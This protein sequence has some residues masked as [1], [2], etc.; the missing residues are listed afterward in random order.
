MDPDPIVLRQVLA[1]AIRGRFE[2]SRLSMC[3]RRALLAAADLEG[4]ARL[5]G[6]KYP[7]LRRDDRTAL[8]G[9]V[10]A[11]DATRRAVRVL[12]NAGVRCLVLKGIAVASLAWE[13]PG[14]RGQADVDLLIAPA[15]I[16]RAAQVLR[17]AGLVIR[18]KL[19]GPDWHHLVLTMSEP[20]A[21]SLEL[22]R[23][24]S[25]DVTIAV[26]ASELIARRIRVQTANGDLPALAHEDAV[27]YLG[28][29]AAVHAFDRLAWLVDIAGYWRRQP[30]DWRVAVER[31]REWGA[32][33]P[34]GLAWAEAVRL[35]DAPI[36][37]EALRGLR[38]SWARRTLAR[39]LLAGAQRARGHT[40]DALTR[41]FRLS[42]SSTPRAFVATLQRK[43][44]ARSQGGSH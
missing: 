1:D 37:P 36:P 20:H 26:T 32:E 41:S 30:V 2:L 42:L 8:V 33:L 12:E 4:V 28:L 24:L 9:A 6:A 17:T 38:V 22:H 31:A 29:H 15:D 40:R 25:V 43:L 5:L 10:L 19:D 18:T 11:D 21:M 23:E 39:A 14:H 3:Q 16:E 44:R 35:L 7:E 27:V 13:E 34:A